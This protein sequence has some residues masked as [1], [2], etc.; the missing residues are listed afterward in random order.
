VNLTTPNRTLREYSHQAIVRFSDPEVTDYTLEKITDSQGNVRFRLNG[1]D[2]TIKRKIVGLDNPIR[3]QDAPDT[4][5][6]RWQDAPDSRQNL[7]LYQA[8]TVATGHILHYKS[9]F[10]ADGY[11]M[12]ELLYSLPLAPGQKK[13]IV[14]FDSSHALTGTESQ[15][16]S[17]GESLSASL[18]NDRSIVDQLSGSIGEVMEGSSNASTSG[19]SAGGGLAGSMGPIGG[20]LGVSGGFANSSSSASQNSARD[21]SQFFG[22]RLR[23]SITQNAESYRRLNATVVTTVK[24]G[25]QYAVTTETIANH[26]HC[27]GLTM[28]YFEVLRHYG[29]YQEI[30]H[31][32]E[33]V[34]VPLLMTNFTVE[35][36]YKWKDVLAQHLL[37]IDSSTYLQPNIF[38]LKGRSHPLLKAFDANERVK[39]N[40]ARVD[41][42]PATETYADGMITQIK[43]QFSMNVNMRRPKTRYDR[44]KSFPIISRTVTTEEFDPVATAKANLKV[45][46]P[47][48]YGPKFKTVEEEILERARIFDAFMTLDANFQTVPPAQCIRVHN[49]FP[50]TTTFAERNVTISGEDFFEGNISDKNLWITYAKIL[51]Y[52]TENGVYEML[53]AYFKDRLISEWDE[54]FYQDVLPLVFAKIVDSI[55][56]HWGAVSTVRA[57]DTETIR[58]EGGGFNLDF[59]TDVMYTGGNR[60]ININ[61]NSQGPV[62]KTRSGLPPYISITS[63]NPDAIKLKNNVKLNIG[64][65]SIDYTTAH[66][67]GSLY[68]GYVN[69][70]LLDGTNLYIPLNAR[71]K[72]NPRKEDEYVVSQLIE[73]LNSNLEHYNKVLW[74]NLDPDRR[75]M[76]L[77]GFYIQVYNDL[78]NPH[79]SLASVV[80]NQ[81]ITITGN[82]MVFPVAA[83]YRVSRSHNIVEDTSQGAALLDHYKP[84]TPV[85]P[86]RIS[87]PTRGVFLEVVQSACDACEKVKPNSSQDWN[88]FGVDEPTPIAPVTTPTPVVTDW[89]AAFKEFAQPL[90]SIQNAPATPEP[91]A[92]LAGM[93]ELLGKAGVFNDITGLQGNQ[94]NAI[95][96]YLSNQENVRAMADMAKGLA[97]QQH[98]T[99][100]SQVIADSIAQARET[101]AISAEE[102]SSLVR[103]HL[104]HQIDGGESSRAQAQEERERGR[105]SLAEA[106]IHA[107]GDG[108]AVVAQRTDADGTAESV[109]ISPSSEGDESVRVEYQVTPLRQPSSRLC[110]ATAATMMMNWKNNNSA[111]VTDVLRDAGEHLSPPEPDK[112]VNMYNR[113]EG[114]PSAQKEAFV[115]ALNMKGEDPA[116]YP[117]S[118]YIE[119][120]RTYGPLWVTTDAA[121]TDGIF[122]P[123]ARILKKIEAPSATDFEHAQLTF[124]DP[125]TG[126]F[127]TESFRDFISALEQMVTDN[128][129]SN[130]FIQIVHFKDRVPVSPSSVGEG[131]AVES[132][133]LTPERAWFEQHPTP[134]DT[135]RG[136]NTL[137]LWNFPIGSAELQEEHFSAIVRF[138]QNHQLAWLSAGTMLEITGRTS[139]SG[140]E[141]ANMALSLQRAE[142]VK[143]AMLT[144]V[145]EEIRPPSA[146]RVQIDGVGSLNP[147]AVDETPDGMALNR[148]VQTVV[149]GV[150]AP[151]IPNR[152]DLWRLAQEYLESRVGGEAVG[153]GPDLMWTP[154]RRGVLAMIP[155]IPLFEDSV[156]PSYYGANV[157]TDDLCRDR[158]AST[159][160]PPPHFATVSILGSKLTEAA[161]RG[162]SLDERVIRSV[163]DE[164]IRTCVEAR[165]ASARRVESLQER[166][167]F[168]EGASSIQPE[169]DRYTRAEQEYF[170]NDPTCLWRY[171]EIETRNP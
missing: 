166:L 151:P 34:F 71:D 118:Q 103:Q 47:W 152:D 15:A 29:V 80:K 35:N 70:D 104:Q 132:S 8:V 150:S 162:R 81:L 54:I 133:R 67:Y 27:H 97:M 137:L 101:G 1:G 139:S 7:T 160:I 106:A 49:F 31:V 83:G 32:E 84:L 164:F 68:R 78:D 157:P 158:P 52:H 57:G 69:D 79:R 26:N 18:I 30:A 98:N 13:Q 60:N 90:V 130:L 123:H 142:A 41:F 148:S 122:S 6:I 140:A 161:R 66:F 73:H 154:T 108:R 134:R 110:W 21:I 131:Q 85:P 105:P 117:L 14:M 46:W 64:K 10:K 155:R 93:T 11:S 107:V 63:S 100:N 153:G 2:R 44:I 51:G 75:F 58:H 143:T 87:V 116:N 23:Q 94:Q 127:H 50:T 55:S 39:T 25:Q 24:E 146:D 45:N 125:S 74:Y 72:I 40:W 92:G 120:L 62:S 136:E 65:V 82:S 36:I 167:S 159:C 77:D 129:D 171:I 91:G 12:G 147:I 33:C 141:L 88:K 169:I 86:Y 5:N 163:V 76:L 96:T 38:L 61:F 170:L 17:Q 43:G 48:E 42:P 144:R 114:M 145:P 59:S 99:Q 138:L 53:A 102:E 168:Q 126:S 9:V 109:T 28:M 124:N 22:E 4:Q 128:P 56:I 156:L 165:T 3:W 115:T 121:G 149:A 89:R 16:I 112:Y 95:R 37:P 111:L 135:L 19:M 113:N 20:S 119:W